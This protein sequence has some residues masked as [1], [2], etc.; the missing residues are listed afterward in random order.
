MKVKIFR[1][2]RTDLLLE[3]N[4]ISVDLNNP[5]AL[6]VKYNKYSTDHKVLTNLV[7]PWHEIYEL[8]ISGED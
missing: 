7:I 1:K 2:T 8:Q 5:N 3:G 4:E 6:G